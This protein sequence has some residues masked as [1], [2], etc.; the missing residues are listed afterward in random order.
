MFSYKL[1]C[2]VKFLCFFYQFRDTVLTDVNFLTFSC[3]PAFADQMSGHSRCHI[4]LH[5]NIA[6]V[7]SQTLTRVTEPGI[8]KMPSSFNPVASM[9]STSCTA[10]TSAF[11]NSE[12]HHF[13]YTNLITYTSNS[14]SN[15]RLILSCKERLVKNNCMQK[16]PLLM[17]NKLECGPMPNVMAALPNIGG[18]LCSTP[19]SLA[20]A[21]Y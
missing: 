19:Q 7:Q 1:F 5:I 17:P 21:H 8:L 4:S 10:I 14:N 15:F 20:D 11:S 12:T 6:T 3:S 16:C 18:A 2:S 9:C 13:S